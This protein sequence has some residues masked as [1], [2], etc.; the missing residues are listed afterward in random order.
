MTRQAKV[1][2]RRKLAGTLSELPNGGYRFV[3][4]DNYLADGPAISLTLPLQ[5][6]AFQLF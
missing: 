1:Y 4:D 3:Y 5:A 2:Y 6:E